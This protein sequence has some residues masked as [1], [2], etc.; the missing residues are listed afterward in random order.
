MRFVLG[1]VLV[2]EDGTWRDGV[3]ECRRTAQWPDCIRLPEWDTVRAA[4]GSKRVFPG[5]SFPLV[6]N[7]RAIPG[8][9][10]SS[11]R[12]FPCWISSTS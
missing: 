4:S 2:F 3:L 8:V 10:A 12:Y 5:A 11:R 9:P 7:V 1:V 6:V